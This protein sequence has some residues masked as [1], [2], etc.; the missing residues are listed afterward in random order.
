MHRARPGSVFAWRIGAR[1]L[2]PVRALSAAL[3]A[4]QGPRCYERAQQW[5]A[6]GHAVAAQAIE[7]FLREQRSIG[8]GR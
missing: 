3:E 5:T 8:R 4:G 7:R 2:D 6:A 1:L